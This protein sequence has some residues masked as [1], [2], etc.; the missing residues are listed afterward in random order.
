MKT[1]KKACGRYQSLFNKEKKGT[2][3]LRKIQKP[4]R[5]WKAKAG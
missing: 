3:R 5:K 1:T 4:T 2:I